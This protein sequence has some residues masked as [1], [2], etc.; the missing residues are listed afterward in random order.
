MRNRHL[1]PDQQAPLLRSSDSEDDTCAEKSRKRA[2]LENGGVDDLWDEVSGEQPSSEH[3]SSTC[4][5][6]EDNG[7]A[8]SQDDHIAEKISNRKPLEGRPKS[9]YESDLNNA[10]I[11]KTDHPRTF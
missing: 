3:S 4:S 7:S 11:I 8:G 2:E 6:A 1:P 9:L 10:T 5:S